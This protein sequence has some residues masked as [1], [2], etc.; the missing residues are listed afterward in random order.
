MS[1][2][3]NRQNSAAAQ[4]RSS[5]SETKSCHW[6]C[7]RIRASLLNGEHSSAT[8]HS[9]SKSPRCAALILPR[10]ICESICLCSY[11][12][13][14]VKP[15]R[16]ELQVR[17]RAGEGSEPLLHQARIHRC[18]QCQ[19]QEVHERGRG[20]LLLRG[21]LAWLF[22]GG[23]NGTAPA[24]E[25]LDIRLH[26]VRA[27]CWRFI[28][29]PVLFRLPSWRF[30]SLSGQP[31]SNF[32][33]LACSS[34]L[35]VRRSALFAAQVLHMLA[36]CA[37]FENVAVREDEMPELEVLARKCC[38]YEIKGGIENKTGKISI[39]LQAFVSKP[40]LESFSLIADLMYVSSNAGRIVRA[41][42]EICLRRGWSSMADTTLQLCKCFDLQLWPHQVRP[43]SLA[44][45]LLTCSCSPCASPPCVLPR[46]QV[47][48]CRAYPPCLSSPQRPSRLAARHWK[49]RHLS[50]PRTR[51]PAP[52]AA[53]PDHAYPG[54]AL[55]DGGSRSLDGGA[56]GHDGI[57]YWWGIKPI[58]SGVSAR[59]RLTTRVSP[60]GAGSGTQRR[61][62][63]SA[64][65]STA[66]PPSPWRQTCSPSP[67]PSC[68][69]SSSSGQGSSGTKPAPSWHPG[70]ARCCLQPLV[71]PYNCARRKDRLHGGSLRWLVLVEDSDNEHIYHS[72]AVSSLGDDQEG[73]R[74]SGGEARGRR[75]RGSPILA[76]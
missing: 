43:R 52:I 42:H 38:P 44:A 46:F 18:L 28:C 12:A 67:G 48:E 55:Q 22:D 4:L 1:A 20:N 69:C 13:G 53:V 59:A 19:S 8:R 76:P 26:A 50:P 34:R 9:S 71:S 56:C 57:R 37:E 45:P 32:H 31:T 33:Y 40:K 47:P 41:L 63:R 29:R 73:R 62:L 3:C 51:L 35:G 17:H 2:T 7:R 61:G 70:R 25:L 54:A 11:S 16:R 15:D 6:I 68:A 60:Q 14:T 74:R 66:S 23:A 49:C 5:P 30:L 36:Q 10:G 75:T 64:S 65:V 21:S 72:G 39:L 24:Q 27:P 58:R